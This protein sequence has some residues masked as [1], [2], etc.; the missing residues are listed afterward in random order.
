MLQKD[1]VGAVIAGGAFDTAK[2]KENT[3]NFA[4]FAATAAKERQFHQN[5]F[6]N[7]SIVG[8]HRDMRQ[9]AERNKYQYFLP[10][11]GKDFEVESA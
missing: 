9:S 8:I 1:F 5:H 6:L 10:R 3:E 7:D 11:Q 4:E 2:R